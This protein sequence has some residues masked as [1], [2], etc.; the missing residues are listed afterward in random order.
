MLI[1]RPLYFSSNFLIN[2]ADK[3]NKRLFIEFIDRLEN[4]IDL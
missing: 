2:G 4:I 1:S 3:R